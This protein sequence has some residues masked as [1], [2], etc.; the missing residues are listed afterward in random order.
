[1]IKQHLFKL[2][3]KVFFFVL[4]LS[5]QLVFA[6]KAS[7][8]SIKLGTVTSENIFQSDDYYNW[9][10]SVIAGD[11]GKFYMFYSRW[12][13]G[14]RK[15][16][17]DPL[18]YIFNGF[19]GWMKYSE[20]ACAVSDKLLGPYKFVKTVL[21]HAGSPGQWDKF[22]KHNAHIRKFDGYYYLYYISSSF[23]PNFA[24]K[25]NPNPSKESLQWMKYNA[26]Q[27]I[28]VVKAKTIKDLLAGNYTRPAEPIMTVDHQQTF[29]IANNPS[30]TKGPDGKYY[31]M[32]KSRIPG[33]Q[34]TFWM[35]RS[36]QPDGGFK[37][38]SN[39]T[40]DKD[41]SSEDP[42]MWYDQKLKRF[43]AI[44]KYYATSLKYAPEFGCLYLI[45][46]KNG[47]DWLPAKNSLVSLKELNF[48]DGTKTKLKNLER[49]FVYTDQRGKPLAVFAAGNILPPG[50]G[51]VNHVDREHN[52]FIVG[53]SVLR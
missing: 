17:D 26:A 34:M 5:G 33:G 22:T 15:L 11:D 27:S 19:Q 46:S 49:P 38:I 44:A 23:D 1:M 29:E 45:E 24:F 40:N 32:Y 50:E 4:L 42:S 25:N 6:Q 39:V 43:F 9:C 3:K 31:M 8:L 16:D 21:P 51:D 41:L 52:S 12:P 14:K 30:V 10:P 13:H 53:F 35:A 28:G 47:K 36:V 2:G 20:I 7:D 18:N 37:T 48:K